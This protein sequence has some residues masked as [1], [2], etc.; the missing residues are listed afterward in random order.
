[1]KIAILLTA[2]LA[3][4]VA[5]SAQTATRVATLSPQ[6]IE[7]LKAVKIKTETA[8]APYTVKLSVTVKKIYDNMLSEHEDQRLRKKL[9]RDLHLYTGKLL[10]IRG[11]AYRDTL[12]VLTPA[13]RQI[14]RE[15]LKKPDAPQDIG[16]LIEKTFSIK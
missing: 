3:L 16:E 4:T 15:A 2:I 8:S 11:Q 12:A 7:A 13:Q 1:M 14:L 9:A 10:D 6:Q 5:A